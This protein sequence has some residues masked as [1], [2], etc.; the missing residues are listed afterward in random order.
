MKPVKQ[1]Y[2]HDP[3]NGVWGDCH[4]ACIASMLDLELDQVP[5]F[6]DGGPSDIEFM[7]RVDQFLATLDMAQVFF[8][9]PTDIDHVHQV[10]RVSNPGIYWILGGKST[11]GCA[12]SVI[13]LDDKIV[14]DPS[15]NDAGIVAPCDEDGCYSVTVIVHQRGGIAR[16]RLCQVENQ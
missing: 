16:T 7:R 14:H 6:G 1:R 3:A 9:F 10:M 13:C 11:T 5:H 8:A 12:H 2:R 4:R 15:L